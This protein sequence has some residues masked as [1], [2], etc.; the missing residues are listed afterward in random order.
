MDVIK[1]GKTIVIEFG[2]G[3]PSAPYAVYVHERTELWHKIGEAK[4][5][6]RTLK[7]SAPHWMNRIA[8]R[9][10]LNRMVK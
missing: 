7:E 10:N 8:S 6:E 9:V 5:M 1:R 4:F 3:G 2:A